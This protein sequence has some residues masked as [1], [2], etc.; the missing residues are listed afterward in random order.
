MKL[1]KFVEAEAEE[2]EASEEGTMEYINTSSNV[3][4]W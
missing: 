4:R 1:S 3:H 2:G